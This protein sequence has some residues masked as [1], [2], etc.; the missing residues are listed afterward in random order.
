MAFFIL[1][2]ILII[3]FS[4][5]FRPYRKEQ[6]YNKPCDN[7]LTDVQYLE[8]MIPHHQV[9]VD[10]SILLKKISKN[11]TMQNILRKIIWIQKYEIDMMKDLIK[12]LP[13]NDMSSDILKMK[14]IYSRT[15]GDFTKP[16]KLGLTKTYCDPHFFDPEKHNEHLKHMKLDNEMY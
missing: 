6:F 11:P 15:I 8:H 1:I 14:R 7:N 3:L 4:V 16:N 2:T 13:R 9:A 12:T 10:I 5:L